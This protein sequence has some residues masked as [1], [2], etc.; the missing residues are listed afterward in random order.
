VAESLR[1]CLAQAELMP[2]RTIT[3]SIG[4]SA[5]SPGQSID[6][7]TQ[8]ADAALYEAKRLGRNRVVVSPAL[9]EDV[10]I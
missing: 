10:L 6:A 5:L 9:I 2:G 1:E 8:A 4:V 7:W 3:V